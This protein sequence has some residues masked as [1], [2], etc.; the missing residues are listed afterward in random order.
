ML[1]VVCGE[2]VVLARKEYLTQI[3]FYKKKGFRTKEIAN[4]DLESLCKSGASE[5]DLFGTP[6]VYVIS[7]LSSGYKGRK[8]MPLKTA[9]IE[10]AKSKDIILIDWEESRS[11]YELSSLKKIATQFLESKPLASIFQLLDVCVPGKLTQF[12][13]LLHEVAKTQEALFIYTLLYRHIR[14]L[15]LAQEDIFDAKTA[16]WQKGKLSAQARLWPTQKLLAFYEGLA[17]IDIGMKTS[18][19]PFDVLKSLELLVCYFLGK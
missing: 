16:P 17:K 18:T 14:K 3:D 8:V 13:A 19:N 12:I 2:D 1:I 4:S 9:I 15:I 10:L 6:E 11:A 7:K 5:I